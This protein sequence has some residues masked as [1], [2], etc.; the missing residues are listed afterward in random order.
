MKYLEELSLQRIF[1][2]TFVV[3]L[4]G[5]KDLASEIIQN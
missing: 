2:L 5:K 1:D 3:K 4:M